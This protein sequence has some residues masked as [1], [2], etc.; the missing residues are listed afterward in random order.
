MQKLILILALLAITGKADAQQTRTEVT[1]S[2]AVADD[3]KPNSDAIPD[4]YAISGRFERVLVLRFKYQADLLTGLERVVKQQGIRN[5][6]I[7]SGI[8]S[9]RNY[10]I[11]VVSNRTFPSKNVYMKDSTA[12]ADLVSMNGYVIDG[13]VHAHV[14]L[15][16]ADKAFGGHLETGTNVF[17]FAIVTIGVLNDSMD[18]S[19]V[20]DKTY[21]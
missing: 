4:A 19:R 16:D 9:V 11:H 1:R 8:G 21:R 3:S 10:E 14:T 13:R 12:P 7:L 2:T 6:V 17:T 18:L 20:D 15:T 5:A